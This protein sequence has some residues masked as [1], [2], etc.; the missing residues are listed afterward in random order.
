[1]VIWG[2]EDVAVGAGPERNQ[3]EAEAERKAALRAMGIKPLSPYD[4]PLMMTAAEPV[5]LGRGR[6]RDSPRQQAQRAGKMHY[7][8]KS[9][10]PRKHQSA[11]Y[12]STGQC[13]ECVN[14]WN[15]QNSYKAQRDW[16]ERKKEEIKANRLVANR[17]QD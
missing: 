5:K 6:W 4:S 8:S 3:A 16:R 2:G 11:R 10:C 1:M 9:L 15:V 14:D 13:V 7:F 12:T 17:S